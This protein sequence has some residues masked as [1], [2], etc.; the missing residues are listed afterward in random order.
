MT[1][2]SVENYNKIRRILFC[3]ANNPDKGF[4][5]AYDWMEKTYRNQLGLNG[6][7]GLM[8]ELKFYERYKRDY[9]LTVAGDM[10]DHAD[11]LVQRQCVRDYSFNQLL[12][13]SL[14]FKK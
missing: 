10:A 2:N 5:K 1:N 6:Y 4:Y 13:F 12:P 9:K 8:A 3:T 7:V 11:S 14:L